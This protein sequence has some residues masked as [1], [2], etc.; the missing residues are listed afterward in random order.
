MSGFINQTFIVLVLVPL[1]F[2]GLLSTKCLS[3]NNQT[4]TVRPTFVDY[5]R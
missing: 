5:S 4:C 1:C 2:G 3:M